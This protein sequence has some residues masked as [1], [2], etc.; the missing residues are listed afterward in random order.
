MRMQVMFLQDP[1]HFILIYLQLSRQ[2]SHTP[3]SQPF[4]WLSAYSV[5]YPL[6]LGSTISFWTPSARQLFESRD[7]IVL[8]P[9]DPL[10]YPFS[11]QPT[12]PTNLLFPYPSTIS[13]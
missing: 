3:S 2:C 8:K 6:L 12:L 5:Y 13:Q 10:D 9:F 11:F 4:R 1:M 7:P